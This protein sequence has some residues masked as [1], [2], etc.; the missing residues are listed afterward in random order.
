MVVTKPDYEDAMRSL[1][2]DQKSQPHSQ[3]GQVIPGKPMWPLSG[4]HLY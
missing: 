4:C 1:P 3:A 2:R